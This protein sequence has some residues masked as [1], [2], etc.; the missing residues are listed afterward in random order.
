MREF[1]RIALL[2]LAALC[3]FASAADGAPSSHPTISGSAVSADALAFSLK[4]ADSLSVPGIK[5]DPQ[6]Q[7]E[8]R[9]EQAQFAAMLRGED[10]AKSPEAPVKAASGSTASAETSALQAEADRIKQQSQSDK[11]AMHVSKADDSTLRGFIV[12]GFILL[13][14]AIV[15]GWAMWHS[16]RAK[17]RDLQSSWEGAREGDP[18]LTDFMLLEGNTEYENTQF[19]NSEFSSTGQPAES[20]SIEFQTTGNYQEEAGHGDN[21]S[22]P[23]AGMSAV[24]VALSAEPPQPKS[25]EVDARK[26]KPLDHPFSYRRI[27]GNHDSWAFKSISTRA[28][29]GSAGQRAQKPID[30]FQLRKANEIYDVMQLAESWM[31]VH[32][33]VDVLA[34][35][36]PFREVELPESPIPWLCLL[37]VYRVLGDKE[38][39]EAILKRIKKIFN[40]KMPSLD[41]VGG[42]VP[43]RRL[44]D[45]PNIVETIFDLWEGDEIVPYLESLLVDNRDGTRDGFDLPVY[46]N[47]LQLIALAKDTDRSKRHNHITHGKAYAILYS[48]M[49]VQAGETSGA[50]PAE[51]RAKPFA[52]HAQALKPAI[53]T[54]PIVMGDMAPEITDFGIPADGSNAAAGSTPAETGALPEAPKPAID[55]DGMSSMSI[56]LHLALAYQ[57]IGD[58]EGARLLLDEVI[59]DGSV[60]QSEKAKLMLARMPAA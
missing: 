4:S 42:K 20:D 16:H 39:Y 38:K 40:V 10:A 12:M 24:P 51:V 43:I 23:I 50:S 36:E 47:I 52:A 53:R 58:E 15:V 5:G 18:G 26:I 60:D 17:I 34:I 49:P 27:A 13:V 30:P 14:C 25:V 19:G 31:S 3:S 21:A 7:A 37:D 54:A 29:G 41:A 46:R 11:V 59:K 22:L 9:A 6:R 44:A 8:I 32:D 1:C 45:Y 55:Y 56:K 2:A 33:P 35:L 57:D 48:E 28:H